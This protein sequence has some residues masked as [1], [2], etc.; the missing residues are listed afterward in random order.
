VP[1]VEPDPYLIDILLTLLL[2]ALKEV[3]I[4]GLNIA[5]VVEELELLLDGAVHSWQPAHW[6]VAT[7]MSLDPVSRSIVRGWRLEPN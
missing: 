5:T 1:E 7:Q 3:L 6:L 2:I 4:V